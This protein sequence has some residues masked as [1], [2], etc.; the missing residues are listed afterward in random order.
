MHIPELPLLIRAQG[1]LGGL[2]GAWMDIVEGKLPVNESYLIAIFFL[3]LSDDW[4]GLPA[5]TGT[6]SLKTL[7]S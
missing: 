1:C 7:R 6:Q 5:K 3:D 2:L 4:F